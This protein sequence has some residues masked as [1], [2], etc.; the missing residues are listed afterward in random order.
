MRSLLLLLCVA[1][2]EHKRR[3]NAEAFA[4]FR[5]GNGS[6]LFR[7]VRKAGGTSMLKALEDVGDEIMTTR[8]RSREFYGMH[9][10][11]SACRAASTGDDA[12]LKSR[13]RRFPAACF[14]AA[15]RALYVTVVRDPLARVHSEFWYR[16]P[17]VDD[18]AERQSERATALP[19][20]ADV[21][22]TANRCDRQTA[23]EFCLSPSYAVRTK[24]GRAA[25]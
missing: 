10:E 25:P 2:G 17:R 15:P 16:G 7:H 5:A 19:G 18:E 6:L 4:A 23:V 9:M 11:F 24:L 14:E 8:N 13:P 21:L 12:T 1:R 20:F 22:K 3:D